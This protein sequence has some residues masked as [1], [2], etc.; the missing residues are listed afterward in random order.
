MRYYNMTREQFDILQAAY[1]KHG[2]DTAAEEL[3]TFYREVDFSLAMK[4]L[5]HSTLIELRLV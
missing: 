1:K 2:F 3:H 5:E 4:N